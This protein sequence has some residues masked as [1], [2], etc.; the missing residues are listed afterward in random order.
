MDNRPIGFFDS[1]LGGLTCIPFLHEKLPNEKIVYYG[2][3]ART[4]YGSKSIENIKQFSTQ[5]VEYL[6]SHDVKLIVIACN[7]VSATSID[8]L[9]EKFPEVPIIGIIEPMAK[10]IAD[11][12]KNTDKFGVIGTKVTINSGVYEQ[13]VKK[14]NENISINSL[15][16]PALV[17][18]IEEGITNNEIMDLTIKYYI[19]DFKKK[20]CINKLVL[21]CTHYPIIQKNIE[22][23]YPDMELLN[24]SEEVINS[25]SNILEEKGMLAES[26]DRRNLCYASDLSENFLNMIN[27]FFDKESVDTDIMKFYD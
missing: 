7:T 14:Y 20:K 18:L 22:R 10:K 19:D 25:V 13:K 3:T 15:A 23:L 21:G 9:K 8:L 24:P 4:P 5:I 17:P 2:D 27:L 16:C 11:I 1:G 26:N 6:V 12:G